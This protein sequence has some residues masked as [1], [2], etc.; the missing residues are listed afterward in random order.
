[1]AAAV[2][3]A[4]ALAG[5]ASATPDTASAGCEP[6]D[7]PV[8]LTF[9]SWVPGMDQVVAL[10]NEKNPDIHRPEWQLRY[11]PE[12]LQPDQG[13]QRTRRWPGRV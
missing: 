4:L 10:W 7:G 3:S 9:T 2:V 1:M 12:L 13:R 8:D 6:S 11:V 5:C